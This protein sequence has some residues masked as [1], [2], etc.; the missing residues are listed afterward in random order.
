MKI[1][2]PLITTG[3]GAEVYTRRLAEGLAARGHNVQLDVA[4]HRFQYAPWLAGLRAPVGTDVVLANSWSAAAFSGPAP[5]V[6][7]VHH[8][9]HDPALSAHKTMP[10]RIFHRAFV[11]PMERRAVMRSAAVIA[12]SRTT[13]DAVHRHLGDAPVDVVLNGV[14]TGYF[15]PAQHR[16]PRDPAAPLELLF[17]GK[18]SRRKGFDLI[19][20]VVARLGEACR[21]TCI[22]PP[23][24]RGLP[25]PPARYLG[26]VSLEALRE[27]YRGSDLLL[28]P[29]RLEGFGYAA[30]EALACG[31]PVLCAQGGAVAEIVPDSCGIACPSDAAACAEAVLALA[32][33][34]GRHEAMRR[35]ARAHAVA[36]LDARRWITETENVLARVTMNRQIPTERA[37]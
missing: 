11:F 23:P 4:P 27:A 3:T 2:L 22:G 25:R 21:L 8:V 13:A 19:A 10:Q 28:F 6:T 15:H 17:V 34:P 33:D 14:D 26:R 32:A 30:A 29:S 24:E 16:P 7:A 36:S 5:L 18:P 9:V 35:S 37:T 1:W 12:V 20:E 31:L